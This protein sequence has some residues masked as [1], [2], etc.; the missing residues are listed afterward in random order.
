MSVAGI[1]NFQLKFYE[2]IRWN[3]QLVYQNTN[4]QFFDDSAAEL[5]DQFSC[6][7][8]IHFLLH[9]NIDIGLFVIEE[10]DIKAKG[11]M[12]PVT[13]KPV[14][15]VGSWRKRRIYVWWQGV[16]YTLFTVNMP[17]HQAPGFPSPWSY[18]RYPTIWNQFPWIIDTGMPQPEDYTD[19]YDVSNT[20][21]EWS[22]MFPF[23]EF[24]EHPVSWFKYS[25]CAYP[26]ALDDIHSQLFPAGVDPDDNRFK[27][28]YLQV[29]TKP[30]VY[31]SDAEWVVRCKNVIPLGSQTFTTTAWPAR[32][33]STFSLNFTI[34]FP[35][36]GGSTNPYTDGMNTLYKI[37]SGTPSFTG[38]GAITETI[39]I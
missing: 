32:A 23:I 30:G 9:A 11:E 26:T 4:E 13:D 10:V 19:P 34:S 21:T 37:G 7:T 36:G 17:F 3:G 6:Y 15:P 20:W 16:E 12:G 27:T 31:P 28:G 14:Y 25:T 8:H 39:K 29:F 33:I 22:W 24:F 38:P 2:Y 18:E 1:N 35:D 5:Y